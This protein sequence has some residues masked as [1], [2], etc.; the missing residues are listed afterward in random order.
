M[1]NENL[2]LNGPTSVVEGEDFT[3]TPLDYSK[4][5]ESNTYFYWEY[6]DMSDYYITV[7]GMTE[8]SSTDPITIEN[9]DIRDEGDYFFR[10]YSGNE[11]CDIAM[12]KHTLDVI[13]KTSPCFEELSTQYL[14]IDESFSND[15]IYQSYTPILDESWDNSDFEVELSMPMF[16]YFLRLRFDIPIPDYSSTYKLR[17]SIISQSESLVDEDPIIHADIRFCPDNVSGDPYR[18]EDLQSNL[19]LKRQ[20]NLMYLSFCDVVFTHQ[21][22]PDR[23][24]TVSGKVEVPL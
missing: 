16:S 23:T 14:I 1:C 4:H 19:Y 11:D 6:P 21:T 22:Y 17:N 2:Q 8:V 12:G 10:I 9:A 3:L 7:S 15:I 18:V 24:I 13:P 5:Q 20:G